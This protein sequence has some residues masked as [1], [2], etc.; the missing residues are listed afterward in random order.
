MTVIDTGSTEVETVVPLRPQFEG[1]NVGPWIG[2][3]HVNY[4]VEE[5]VLAHFRQ[6][7][8]DVRSLYADHGL[9]LEIVEIDTR[10]IRA[11]R[12]ED[13]FNF[14][15][16]PS[17]RATG[18]ELAFDV[19]VHDDQEATK[20]TRM[21]VAKVTV[22]LRRDTRWPVPK[23]TPP[24]GT[25]GDA[26]DRIVRPKPQ[27]GFGSGRIGPPAR[28]VD[29]LVSGRNALVW[30]MRVP[31]FYCHFTERLQM[32]GYLRVMEE[33]VDR[34][35]TDRGVSIRSLLDESQLI[36]AVPRSRISML[37]EAYMDEDLHTVLVIDQVFK[38]LTF[39]ATMECYVV[40]EGELVITAVG[41]ITHGYA[42]LDGRASWSLARLDDRLRTAL[43]GVGQD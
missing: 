23:D 15:V 9:C 32:S 27:S 1:A 40:R 6:Q 39:T 43:A 34:F 17:G 41:A 26:V 33:V 20:A 7:G 19:V 14:H 42:R 30:K 36:P 24:P 4:M 10:I 35:L 12:L 29:N 28:S 22:M 18:A 2:F 5:A 31:Y 11:L 37:E 16:S 21:V 3:K 8:R 38:D 25:T 13:E